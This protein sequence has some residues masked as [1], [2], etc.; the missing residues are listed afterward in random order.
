MNINMNIADIIKILI[1]VF[2][3]GIG[4]YAAVLPASAGRFT[5]FGENIPPRGMEEIRA[6]LGGAFIGLGLAPFFFGAGAYKA[7]GVTY[8]GIGLVRT[9]SA[10]A[11]E[12]GRK[13]STIISLISEYIFAALLLVLP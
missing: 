10:V 13:P 5:G 9:V 7:M 3:I 6:V 12:K 8:L 1:A 2:T 4:I 11:L